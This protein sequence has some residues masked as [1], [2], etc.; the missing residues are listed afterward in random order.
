MKTIT[1]RLGT[2]ATARMAAG[3]A[4]LLNSLIEG[5]AYIITYELVRV[6]AL[7]HKLIRVTL[8]RRVLQTLQHINF[9]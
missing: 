2:L 3:Y 1:I 6:A 8:M 9:S 4:T 5:F 7:S